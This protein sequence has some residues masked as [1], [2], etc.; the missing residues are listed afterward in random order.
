MLQRSSP[1]VFS[2]ANSILSGRPKGEEILNCLMDRLKD[3][4]DGTVVPLDFSRIEFLDISCA[5]E[6]LTKLLLRIRSGELEDRFVFIRNAN[7]SVRETVQAVL[8]LRKL[9]IL[10]CDETGVEILGELKT[11]IRETLEVLLERKRLTSGEL[12]KALSKNVNIACNRL[13][14][15]Q[16]MGLVCRVREDSLP[17]GGRQYRYESIF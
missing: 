6:F 2:S 3:E 1:F 17:G 15:L 11:P 13:N 9:A 4:E 12:A 10:F 7:P 5:D 8:Q 16:R 14:V